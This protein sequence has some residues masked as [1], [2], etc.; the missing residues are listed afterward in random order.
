[1]PKDQATGMQL[2]LCHNAYG[3]R[4]F[5]LRSFLRV[6]ALHEVP[7]EFLVGQLGYGEHLEPRAKSYRGLQHFLRQKH[8]IELAPQQVEPQSFM[9]DYTGLWGMASLTD[10]V[11][12]PVDVLRVDGPTDGVSTPG[13]RGQID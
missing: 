12:E 6:D 8:I 3:T 13:E 5:R 7:L 4:V 11:E 1:M 10:Q 2:H 9:S